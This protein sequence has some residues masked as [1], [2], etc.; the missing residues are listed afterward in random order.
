[1]RFLEASG[2]VLVERNFRCRAGEL[3]LVMMHGREL[4]IVEVRYRTSGAL[5]D[6]A[7]TV[8]AGKR[9]RLLRAAAHYLQRQ[10]HLADHPVRFDMVALTG[11]LDRPVCEWIRCAFTTND[12]DEY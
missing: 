11:S 12:V 6:P 7:L 10:R 9:R 5:V 4:V 3:D 1:M 2:L 8:C